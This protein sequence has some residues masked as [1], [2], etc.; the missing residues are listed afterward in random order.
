MISPEEQ[1]ADC[2]SKFLRIENLLFYAQCVIVEMKEDILLTEVMENIKNGRN[3][4]PRMPYYQSRFE[5]T[6][7]QGLKLFYCSEI[8]NYLNVQSKNKSAL[9]IAR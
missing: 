3:S 4:N 1:S 6:I 8:N 9:H 7:E 2:L 5:L